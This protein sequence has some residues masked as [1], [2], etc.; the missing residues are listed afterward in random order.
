MCLNDDVESIVQANKLCNMYGLDTI[1]TSAVIAFAMEAYE[2]G[3][4]TDCD[5]IFQWL[6]NVDKVAGDTGIATDLGH[7]GLVDVSGVLVHNSGSLLS[8]LTC[9]GGGVAC[10]PL[11]G[12][13][14]SIVTFGPLIDYIAGNGCADTTVPTDGV[15]DSRGKDGWYRDFP[16]ASRPRER[17]LGQA[18]LLGGLL[19]FTTYQPYDDLCQQE[20]QAYLYGLYYQTGTAWY[21]SVFGA[22]GLDADDNVKESIS[23]GRG[24]ATT[25][26]LHVGEGGPT[27]FVQTSTGEIVEMPQTNLPLGNYKTGRRSWEE[28]EQ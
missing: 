13:G 17:N 3:I 19:T 5:G 21:S 20:G 2:K 22:L 28:V 1:S 8:A 7:R 24:L 27:A 6:G 16:V 10:L 14:A 11:D 25:P 12:A 26:N 18:T 9:S 15:L 23:L 4:L